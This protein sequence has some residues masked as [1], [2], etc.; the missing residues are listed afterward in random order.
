MRIETWFAVFCTASIIG[1]VATAFI[2]EVM[3]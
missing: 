1:I 2:L 3:S